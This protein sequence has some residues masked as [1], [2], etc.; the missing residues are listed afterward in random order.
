MWNNLEINR[1]N[2]YKIKI[3]KNICIKNPSESITISF[4]DNFLYN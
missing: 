2:K 3:L 1:N 4:M